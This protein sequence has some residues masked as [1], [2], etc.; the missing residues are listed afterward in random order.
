VRDDGLDLT[1]SAFLRYDDGRFAT[2]LTSLRG[3]VGAGATI[4][5]STGYV[6]YDE[7]FLSAGSFHL[8]SPPFG[9]PRTVTV[10]REGNGYVPMFRAVGE[11]IADGLLEHPLRPLRDTI[12]VM[13]IIDEVRRQLTP[14]GRSARG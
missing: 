6:T 4:G 13:E 1:A 9:E 7:P 8:E 2:S 12:E 5:G 3:F 14:P 10:E 11:A